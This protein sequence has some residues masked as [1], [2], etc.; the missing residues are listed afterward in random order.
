MG[1]NFVDMNGPPEARSMAVFM[2]DVCQEPILG[3]NSGLLVWCREWSDDGNRH[4]HIT[5]VSSVHKGECDR[6][7]EATVGAGKGTLSRE[8]ESVV[9]DLR[10][11]AGTP[12][13]PEREVEYVAPRPSQWTAGVQKS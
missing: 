8:I 6:I 7:W 4:P 13:E 3:P 10:L 12:F 5:V 9:K 11:N 1:I 2:C